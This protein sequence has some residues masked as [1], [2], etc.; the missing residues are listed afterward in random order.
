MIKI[1][2]TDG[3]TKDTAIVITDAD[4]HIE[5]R[6][7]YIKFLE[8]YQ[9]YNDYDGY[10]AEEIGDTLDQ[11]IAVHRF[12]KNDEIVDEL[13]IDYTIFFHKCDK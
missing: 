2:N 13:W 9:E 6:M 10:K 7:F 1:S 8:Y 12:Y 3:K 4:N 11:L 5:A